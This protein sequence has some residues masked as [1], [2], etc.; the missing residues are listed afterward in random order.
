MPHFAGS[1]I[2]REIIHR[3]VISEICQDGKC[4]VGG[5]KAAA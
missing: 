5:G 2:L 3:E 1:Q 4:C